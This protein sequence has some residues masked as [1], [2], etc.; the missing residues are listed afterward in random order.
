MKK[1]LA[2]ALPVLAVVGALAWLNGRTGSE[3][4]RWAL[5]GFVVVLALVIG[6]RWRTRLWGPPV[7]LIAG[8]F[9]L[10][11]VFLTSPAANIAIFEGFAGKALFWCV[12]ASGS[13]V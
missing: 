2:V 8:A 13:W 4:Y 9:A 12:L 7:A 6:W 5:A 3:P 11:A 1:E 10:F